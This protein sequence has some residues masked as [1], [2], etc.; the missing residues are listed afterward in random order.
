MTSRMGPSTGKTEILKQLLRY[1]KTRFYPDI[2]GDIEEE[3][4]VVR[5]YREI[6]E[7]TALL[8][9]HWQTVSALLFQASF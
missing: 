3:D 1:T 9:A 5:M 2:A 8:A 4:T 7:R 6:M